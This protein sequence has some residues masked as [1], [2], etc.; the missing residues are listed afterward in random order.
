MRFLRLGLLLILATAGVMAWDVHAEIVFASPAGRA[1]AGTASSDLDLPVYKPRQ[2]RSPR[3]RMGGQSRSA[4][5]SGDPQLIALVPDHVAF[6]V[7]GNP[8]LCWYLSEQTALPMTITL[9]DSRGI[10]PILEESIPSPTGPG[11]HCVKPRHYGVE[12]KEQEAYRWFVTLVV[13]PDRPSRDVVA[14]G[15]VERVSFDEAC[16]LD[17]PCTETP[18]NRNAVFRYSESGLWYDAISCL[19]ELI[20]R[21][22]EKHSLQQML[23]H[24]LRQ[25]GVNLP[26]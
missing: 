9:V 8:S 22:D 1:N 13:D 23:D 10:R 18:C 26:S 15:V 20:G 19:L 14:G 5:K 24:L 3:A 12:L 16:A 21:D 17:M 25:T 11:I 4:D 6:T 7:T 2:N